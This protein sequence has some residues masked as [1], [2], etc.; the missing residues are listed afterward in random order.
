[1]TT[2]RFLQW[3]G[4]TVVHPPLPFM[5]ST[6]EC[7]EDIN[8][9][10]AYFTLRQEVGR[11]VESFSREIV[12]KQDIATLTDTFAFSVGITWRLHHKIGLDY[13]APLPPY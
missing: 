6:T 5:L 4:E 7:H 3:K 8:L 12:L 13:Q 10:D 2:G 1:M 11:Y 9:N